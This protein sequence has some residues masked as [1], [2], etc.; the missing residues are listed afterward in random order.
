MIGGLRSRG[1]AQQANMLGLGRQAPP[2]PPVA[3]AS[4]DSV[5]GRRERCGHPRLVAAASQWWNVCTTNGTCLLTQDAYVALNTLLYKALVPAVWDTERAIDCALEDWQLDG[6]GNAKA[7][8]REA[9][10]TSLMELA[11]VWSRASDATLPAEEA[12]MRDAAW[13][14]SLLTVVTKSSVSS[15]LTLR[16]PSEVECI[17]QVVAPPQTPLTPTRLPMK[18]SMSRRGSIDSGLSTAAADASAP[19]S[20]SSSVPTDAASDIALAAAPLLSSET[21]GSRPSS[22]TLVGITPPHNL[23]ASSGSSGQQSRGLRA[24]APR[25]VTPLGGMLLQDVQKAVAVAASVATAAPCP[26]NGV[27]SAAPFVDPEPAPPNSPMQS[28]TRRRGAQVHP[29]EALDEEPRETA[30]LWATADAAEPAAAG[31]LQ[32]VPEE[33]VAAAASAAAAA[34]AAALVPGRA[35]LNSARGQGPTGMPAGSNSPRSP[36]RS[37]SSSPAQHRPTWSRSP[38]RGAP[39]ITPGYAPLLT[40]TR[41]TS[42]LV[43]GRCGGRAYSDASLRKG[44]AGLL[45][46]ISSSSSLL[47]L[48]DATSGVASGVGGVGGVAP[49]GGVI[50]VTFKSCASTHPALPMLPP[51]PIARSSS[52]VD[53]RSSADLFATVPSPPTGAAALMAPAPARDPTDAS[54]AAFAQRTAA[55]TNAAR[56]AATA[57]AAAASARAT[58]AVAADSSGS[59]S[60]SRR[61]PPAAHKP[62]LQQALPPGGRWEPLSPDRQSAKRAVSAVRG[63]RTLPPPGPPRILPP[64]ANPPI[65]RVPLTGAPAAQP[66]PA[67]SQAQKTASRYIGGGGGGGG[68]LLT[69]SASVPLYAAPSSIEIT[70]READRRA[71]HYQRTHRPTARIVSGLLASIDTYS[72]N[73]T[74]SFRLAELQLGSLGIGVPHP[75]AAPPLIIPKSKLQPNPSE[76]PKRTSTPEHGSRP[77]AGTLEGTVDQELEPPRRPSSSGNASVKEQP[78]RQRRRKYW[79]D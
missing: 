65:G 71:R 76:S 31:S 36:S 40:Q 15:T 70:S 66:Q 78:A 22:T 55:L 44:Q 54:A 41:S 2:P 45:P 47:P 33:A 48:A 27:T 46:P 3:L 77:K 17:M 21:S 62:F 10:F 28:Q 69:S 14:E 20:A 8:S 25:P 75:E 67:M 79:D 19:D 39:P 18:K 6:M 68:G 35:V 24:G 59:T 61:L 57:R 16:D 34:A 74:N 64:A 60:P 38:L 32:T 63:N 58:G 49:I 26:A 1:A 7:M 12:I 11:E 72:S 37:R 23:R 53:G 43:M 73:A 13:L 42:S 52:P 50:P 4:R 56:D 5:A 51:M 29:R 9:F 30:S